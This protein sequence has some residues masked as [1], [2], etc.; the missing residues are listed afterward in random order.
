MENNMNLKITVNDGRIKVPV[1][2]ESDGEEIG[3][4]RF[5]PTDIGI[6]ARYNDMVEAFDKVVEPLEAVWADESADEEKHA[7]ALRE[8]EARLFEAVDT[9]F[10]ADGAARAFF[11]GMSPFSPVDGKFYC[12]NVLQAVGAFIGEQFDAETA[13]FEQRVAKYTNRAERRKAAKK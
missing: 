5:S 1:L 4:F 12:E 11:G 9:L 3:S 13:K 6:I 8:A 2:R 7:E 10:N